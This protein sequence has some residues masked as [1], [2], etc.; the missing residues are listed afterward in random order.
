MASSW[1]KVEVITPDKP[2]IYQIAE[3]LNIDPDAVLGKLIRVWSWADLQT[4]DG[5]AGSVTKSVIDR[6][7]FISGFADALI[8]VGWMKND[9]GKLV[10]PNFDRHNGESSKKRALTNRRVAEHREKKK[11][12]VTQSPL[13]K[14]LPEE[15]EEEEVYKDP[16]SKGNDENYQPNHNANNAILNNRVPSGG[17]GVSEKFVMFHG[18]EPDQDFTKKAAY[19]GVRLMTPMKPHELA[20]FVTY[21]S[22][23]GKAKT[24]EQWEMA[25]A[26]SIKFQRSKNNEVRNGT[27]QSNKTSN[28]FAGKSKPMQEF[29]QHVNDKYGPDAVT[30]LVE[31]DRAVWGQVEQ[32]E[33]DGTLIDVETSTQRIE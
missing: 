22:S 2:E 28:Q 29:L 6:I 12:K 20:E 30:A 32:E 9:N 26:K 31:N 3:I 33:R 19:W 21:W 8:T 23:E 15:E 16:L 10:L 11:K 13:Q 7:T 4:L 17:F 25:L 18:W 27:S 24:H 14:T 1:I 5:N